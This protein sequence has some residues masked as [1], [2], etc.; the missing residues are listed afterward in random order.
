LLFLNE[1]RFLIA[2]TTG[3]HIVSVRGLV[4]VLCGEKAA[5]DCKQ[6]ENK[7]DDS[8]D[9][10]RI[11]LGYWAGILFLSPL[12]HDRFLAINAWL[13][14]SRVHLVR[15]TDGHEKLG[16]KAGPEPEWWLWAVGI[17]VLS[18]FGLI[19]WLLW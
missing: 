19:S 7:P 17:A 14:P 1:V 10:Y 15:M 12:I 4:H 16:D 8:Y 5:T 3:G 2:G 9:P 18:L 11:V 6:Y 13:Q